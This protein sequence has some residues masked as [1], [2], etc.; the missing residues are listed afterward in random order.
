MTTPA[1]KPDQASAVEPGAIDFDDAAVSLEAVKIR[2]HVAD[3]DGLREL[4]DILIAAVEA[5][6][7]RVAELEGEI[8]QAIKWQQFYMNKAEAA[9]AREVELAGWVQRAI[10]V[11][12][13]E[14]IKNVFALAY[15]HGQEYS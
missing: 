9:E 6:R 4:I 2:R 5:L 3:I 14:R 1:D 12:T 10:D 8:E 13:D 7:E 15:V 11:L